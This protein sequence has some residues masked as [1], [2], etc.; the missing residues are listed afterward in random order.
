MEFKTSGVCSR[1]IRFDINSNKIS[2]VEFVGG[3]P[4]NAKGLAILLEGM[5]VSDAIAKLDGIKCGNRST[6]CPDQMAKA[7]KQSIVK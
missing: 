1:F 5:E 2:N 3:C 7:L 4:G 6:S